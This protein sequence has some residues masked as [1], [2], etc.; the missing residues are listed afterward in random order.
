METLPFDEAIKHEHE[1]ARTALPLQDRVH[2]Y[3]DRSRYTAQDPTTLEVVW[4]NQCANT[5]AR[6]IENKSAGN[7]GQ[8]LHVFIDRKDEDK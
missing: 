7:T 8:N 5:Q 1:R 2:S 4:E 3:I 6:R